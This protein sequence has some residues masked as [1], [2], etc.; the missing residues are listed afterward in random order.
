MMPEGSPMGTAIYYSDPKAA[1]PAGV[2]FK[3]AV[4]APEDTALKSDGQAAVE[5]S[6]GCRVAY[7]TYLGRCTSREL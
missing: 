2:R 3:V 6:P 7:L 1:Y 5:V 4:A